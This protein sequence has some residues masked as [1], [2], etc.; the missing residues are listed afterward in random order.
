MELPL[1]P[2][3]SVLCPGIA[4]PLHIFEDRYRLMIERCLERSEPFGVVLIHSGHEVGSPPSEIAEIGTTAAIRQADRHPDGRLDIVTVGERRFRIDALDRG[5]A[6]WLVG[7]VSLLDEPVGADE[8]RA[9]RAARRIGNRFLRY[10]ELLQPRIDPDDRD[11]DDPA[12]AETPGDDEAPAGA[13]V[14]DRQRGE[15]LMASARRL[16]VSG[17]ATAVSYLLTGLVQVELATRQQLLETPD[18]LTRL[19]RLDDLL[20]REIQLLSRYLRPV[21]IDPAVLAL[22]HN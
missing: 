1:F 16:V 8:G 2:L 3:R 11:P 21:T 13:A 6:P 12:P 20:G 4:L 19:R 9:E 18:T 17:D 14:S 15:L 7:D 10:L 5:G 22:R